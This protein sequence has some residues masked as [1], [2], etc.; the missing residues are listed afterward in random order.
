MEVT[1]VA[2]RE[3]WRERRIPEVEEVR[4]GLWSVPLP[5]AT[6]GIRYVLCYVLVHSDGVTLVDPGWR[7]RDSWDALTDGLARIGRTVADVRSIVVT[8]FHPD[9]LGLADLVAE[10][11]G[12]EVLMHRSDVRGIPEGP[13]GVA[14]VV[15]RTDPFLRRHGLPADEIEQF[16]D[17]PEGVRAMAE[18][19]QPQGF[20]AD[21]EFLDVPDWRIQAVHT[22]GHTP[23]H[24]C[25]YLPE[26]RLLLTGDHL[27]PRITP[28]VSAFPN[29]GDDPLG[30]YLGSLRK[31]AEFAVDEVLPAHEYRF[32]GMTDRVDAVLHHHDE[33]EAELCGI[34][35][36]AK[37]PLTASQVSR[38]LTWSRP[39]EQIAVPMRQSALAET[40]AHLVYLEG[41]GKV[42]RV[43]SD[44]ES[45]WTLGCGRP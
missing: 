42:T 39:F 30:A 26:L 25:F 21:G 29:S 12:A 33:R 41:S 32:A 28:N 7:D 11:S 10:K 6:S 24:L 36:K 4:P 40:L 9:H 15:A 16:R 2:Q 22:P 8:H 13:G 17:N 45:R 18:L 31:T 23:G 34:L 19:R 3:A 43:E 5:N 14:E 1:G 27:L 38:L 35:D 37:Q 20:V 44:D